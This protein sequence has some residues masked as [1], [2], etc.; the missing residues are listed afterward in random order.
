M[1]RKWFLHAFFLCLIFSCHSLAGQSGNNPF[2]IVPG[3]K[4]K[5]ITPA[6]EKKTIPETPAAII[7]KDEKEIKV[8]AEQV[9]I[10]SN[11]IA[12]PIIKETIEAA[13]V[14]ETTAEEDETPVVDEPIK[15]DP[16]IN[17]Q[18]LPQT[19]VEATASE[20]PFDIYAGKKTKPVIKQKKPIIAEEENTQI[21]EEAVLIPSE[22][23]TETPKEE[24]GS[25]VEE[26]LIENPIKEAAVLEAPITTET[27]LQATENSKPLVAIKE[28]L[29][30]KAEEKGIL[31]HLET[32][33]ADAQW[34]DRYVLS[35]IL[36]FIMVA[37]T[38]IININRRFI[39]KIYKA[40]GN[41]NVAKL[42]F[43]EFQSGSNVQYYLS[44]ILFIINMSVFVY[45]LIN[46]VGVQKS[47]TNL[48]LSFAAIL[49]IYIVRHGVLSYMGMIFPL[50]KEVSFFSFNIFLYNILFGMVLIPINV[51]LVLGP[52]N[53]TKSILVTGC[54]VFFIFFIFRQLR[55][56]SIGRSFL[57]T[58]QFHF[59]TYLCSVEIAPILI[60]IKYLMS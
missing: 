40:A 58:N 51:I 57:K 53:I 30:P 34:N 1:F 16:L 46:S 14:I 28:L 22:A 39:S 49:G 15:N 50:K 13:V 32:A 45:L 55:G 9:K 59:F 5:V 6:P 38:L 47:L 25:E 56:V 42:S 26:Q 10:E 18:K 7:P 60:L 3:K 21:T 36:L 23:I 12:T 27:N 33:Q 24:I 2:D 8:E 41:E 44:Y 19:P 54:L 29:S 11:P 4:A 31:N 43:R 37:L 35:G 17:I 48:L 20:N 52:Q